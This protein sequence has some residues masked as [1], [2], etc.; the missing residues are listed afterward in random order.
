MNVCRSLWIGW[1]ITPEVR[2][3]YGVLVCAGH[4]FKENGLDTGAVSDG[5]LECVVNAAIVRRITEMAF[6]CHLPVIGYSGFTYPIK[7]QWI[8]SVRKYFHL[9]IDVHVNWYESKRVNG[10]EVLIHERHKR[11]D[12]R[13]TAEALCQTISQEL[14]YRNRGVKFRH[15]LEFLNVLY[16]APAMVSESGFLSNSDCWEDIVRGEFVEKVALA[17]IKFISDYIREVRG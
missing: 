16:P 15:D 10:V 5:L 13:R 1:A 9:A 11:N 3:D 2:E 14:S 12:V 4:G 6:S 17:H 7:T 8:K